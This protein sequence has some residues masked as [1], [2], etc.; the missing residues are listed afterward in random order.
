M[1]DLEAVLKSFQS[2]AV[3]P[4][5]GS[6]IEMKIAVS[7]LHDCEEHIKIGLMYVF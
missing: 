5:L 4:I 1:W 2:H 3:V 7:L 6:K